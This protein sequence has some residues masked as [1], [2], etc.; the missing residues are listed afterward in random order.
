MISVSPSAALRP[1]VK[2][3]WVSNTDGRPSGAHEHVLPTGAMH[4]VFRLSGPRLRIFRNADDRQGIAFN[5]PVVGGTRTGYY[6]KDV[7]VPVVSMGAQL[8]P[9]AAQS[10]FGVSAAE[11]AERHMP[12]SDLWGMHAEGAWEQ[13]RQASTA[14]QQL[15]TLNRLLEARLPR[16]RGLHPAI[17]QA[18]GAFEHGGRIEEFVRASQY[19]HRGF[20]ALFRQ[21]TGVS[22]KRY[23]R[24]MRFQHLLRILNDATAAPLSELA[25]SVGYSDQ[26]HMNRE[27]REFAG[28]TPLQYRLQ[29]PGFAHHV[30]I[31]APETRSQFY[32]RRTD[33]GVPTMRSLTTTGEHHDP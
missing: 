9:G 10:L 23:S 1:L 26:A 33:R 27:F 28:I 16:V 5:E 25:L 6:I 7:S 2:Q 4:L 21:A 32:S 20:I 15:S 17:A 31:N 22:P 13:L 8:R 24:L 12:L 29:S 19:S 30:A 3:L 18:L 14:Q 11:L